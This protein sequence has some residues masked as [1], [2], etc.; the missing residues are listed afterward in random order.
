MTRWTEASYYLS[1]VANTKLKACWNVERI[2][3]DMALRRWNTAT[4]ARRAGISHKTVDRFLR[5]DVQTPKTAGLIA[6]ALGF[7]VRRYFSH[8]EAVA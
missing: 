4:L 8:V 3:A 5:G 1:T 2:T 6:D 7:S